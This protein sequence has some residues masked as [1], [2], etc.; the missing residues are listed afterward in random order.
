MFLIKKKVSCIILLY[1]SRFA[2]AL[3]VAYDVTITYDM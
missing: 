2:S 1:K 3:T